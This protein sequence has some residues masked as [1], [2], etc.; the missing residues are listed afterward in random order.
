MLCHLAV[1]RF[2]G[3]Q[4]G[5]TCIANISKHVLSCGLFLQENYADIQQYCYFSYQTL[6][7][8]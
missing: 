4:A 1:A 8:V 2:Q 3:K 5:N 6:L 7:C